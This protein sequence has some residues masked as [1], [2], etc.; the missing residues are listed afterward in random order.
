MCGVYQFQPGADA[1]AYVQRHG[2]RMVINQVELLK[3][4][5]GPRSIAHSRACAVQSVLSR[6]RAQLPSRDGALLDARGHR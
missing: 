2:L 4:V 1:M 6:V 3:S 5:C